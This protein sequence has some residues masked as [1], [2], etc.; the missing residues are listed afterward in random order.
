MGHYTFKLGEYTMR[1]GRKAHVRFQLSRPYLHP[2]ILVGEAQCNDGS[3]E[4]VKW[5]EYGEAG[6]GGKSGFDL[7]SPGISSD[8]GYL[9]GL[10]RNCRWWTRGAAVPTIDGE[11]VE[12]C[13]VQAPVISPP[14][15]SDLGRWPWTKASA[16]C[17]KFEAR[18]TDDV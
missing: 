10:C 6:C 17:G 4:L 5:T 13:R 3:W 12:E 8:A 9:P 15:E 18:P 16:G 11:Q 1:N 2:Y 7:M 14:S